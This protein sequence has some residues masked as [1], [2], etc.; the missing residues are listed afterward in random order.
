[1]VNFI[2]VAVD[3]LS[4]GAEA[5]KDVE[6]AE[7]GGHPDLHPLAKDLLKLLADFKIAEPWLTDDL[8]AEGLGVF[9][10]FLEGKKPQ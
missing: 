10:S 6:A 4:T 8:L 2:K 9:D 5:A 7:A 3:A 1:M